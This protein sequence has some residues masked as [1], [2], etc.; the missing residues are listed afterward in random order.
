MLLGILLTLLIIDSVALVGVILLQRSEGG[1]LGMGGGGGGG[2]MSARGTA[3]L[4]TRTTTILAAIFFMLSLSITIIA[5]RTSGVTSVVDEIDMK[6]LD[7]N[8]LVAP[9]PT[10]A[11]PA[12]ADPSAPPVFNVPA[13]QAAPPAAPNFG[14]TPPAAPTL[15]PVTAR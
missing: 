9:T 6:R 10:P 11:P 15:P 12:G 5:G 7:P 1:A 3:D 4:L 14:T 8:A 2:F 13:P